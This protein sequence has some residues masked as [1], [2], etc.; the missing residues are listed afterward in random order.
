MGRNNRGDGGTPALWRADRG[1]VEAA[2]DGPNSVTAKRWS[3]RFLTAAV[4]GEVTEVSD[5]FVACVHRL[6]REYDPHRRDAPGRELRTEDAIITNLVGG[7]AGVLIESEWEVKGRLYDPR[8]IRRLTAH[9]R[10]GPPEVSRNAMIAV[11]AGTVWMYDNVPLDPVVRAACQ[12]LPDER[13]ADDAFPNRTRGERIEDV[14]AGIALATVSRHYPREVAEHFNDFRYALRF[15]TDSRL[16]TTLGYCLCRALMQPHPP[17][18]RNPAA[19]AAALETLINFAEVGE[20]PRR[21]SVAVES[22]IPFCQ[23]RPDIVPVTRVNEM[24]AGLAD[25]DPSAEVADAA[26]RLRGVMTEVYDD[27]TDPAESLEID[28]IKEVVQDGTIS[29]LSRFVDDL[30]ITFIQDSDHIMVGATDSRMG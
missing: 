13:V 28:D 6:V 5:G 16:I 30:Y 7:V 12:T 1:Q 25:E 11:A 22:V 10:E 17:K 29:R 9:V 21:R 23:V 19:T 20:N 4:A 18:D 2:L 24:L 27:G 15:A 26:D 14:Y 3:H 8:L